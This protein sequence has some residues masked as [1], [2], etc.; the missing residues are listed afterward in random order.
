MH[1]KLY[2]VESP[3]S[4]NH[5]NVKL[6]NWPQASKSKQVHVEIGTVANNEHRDEEGQVDFSCSYSHS[7]MAGDFITLHIVLGLIIPEQ[8]ID[9]IVEIDKTVSLSELAV[10]SSSTLG[11]CHLNS[12]DDFSCSKPYRDIISK[13][14]NDSIT[15]IWINTKPAGRILAQTR[16]LKQTAFAFG[17]AT[18]L[19]IADH[20]LPLNETEASST[21]CHYT[22]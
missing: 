7:F 22:V 6:F 16:H 20:R 21:S 4:T 17:L 3:F 1:Y 10:E 12:I 8:S 11:N 13:C 19:E 2:N 18:S 5:G 9:V 14:K 15:H